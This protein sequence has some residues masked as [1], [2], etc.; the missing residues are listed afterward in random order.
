[1]SRH[2]SRSALGLAMLLVGT[3]AECASTAPR[4]KTEPEDK[5]EPEPVEYCKYDAQGNVTHMAVSYGPPMVAPGWSVPLSAIS[6]LDAPPVN[7]QPKPKA[8]S[9]QRRAAAKRWWIR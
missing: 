4:A 5:K 7:R 9:G 6:A 1:V 2:A 8:R 3:G